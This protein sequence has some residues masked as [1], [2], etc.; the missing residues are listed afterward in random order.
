LV[1]FF[2]DPEL[3]AKIAGYLGKGAPDAPDTAPVLAGTPAKTRDF[4][5]EVHS[6]N[7]K[8]PCGKEARKSDTD[9]QMSIRATRQQLSGVELQTA[10][11]IH[12]GGLPI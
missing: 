12:Q 7:R 8:C 9:P 4:Q 11:L 1:Q 3:Q 10:A 2:S 6:W 5:K